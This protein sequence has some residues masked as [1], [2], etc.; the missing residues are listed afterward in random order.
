MLSES[1]LL[2]WSP[3][4]SGDATRP[5]SEEDAAAAHQFDFHDV[6]VEPGQRVSVRAM[7]RGRYAGSPGSMWGPMD[8]A[9]EWASAAYVVPS[10]GTLAVPQ[11]LAARAGGTS[12]AFALGIG[13]GAIDADFG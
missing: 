2:Q 11:L 12:R 10:S 8:L 9:S 1:P 3:I 13:D 5:W 4:R 7:A 6:S